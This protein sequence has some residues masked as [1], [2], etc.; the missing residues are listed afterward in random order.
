MRI[1]DRIGERF[2]RLVVIE[3]A[4]SSPKGARWICRC[5]CGNSHLV[6][7]SNLRS[8]S[9]R[10][11][12]CFLR[13]NRSQFAT[14]HGRTKTSEYVIWRTMR[15]RCQN[16]RRPEYH[17]YGGRGISVCERWSSSFEKFFADMGPRPSAA[18]SLDRRDNDGN[19]EP[20]N[21]RWATPQEQYNNRSSCRVVVYCG[22]QMT[23]TQAVELAGTSYAAIERRIRKGWDPI[24]AIETPVREKRPN[25]QAKRQRAKAE[26]SS[27]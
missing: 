21:C 16:P 11:C 15:A 22:Q 23:L 2:G 25:G 27:K 14:T 8:G 1:V 9:V 20:D 6:S 3:R 10:S 26:E 24:L 17:R 13:E 4:T 12:G 18:H 5:D 19:Y 7:A